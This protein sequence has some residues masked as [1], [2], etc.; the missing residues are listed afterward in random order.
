MWWGQRLGFTLL[1]VMI[2]CAIAVMISAIAVPHFVKMRTDSQIAEAEIHL[3]MIA[4][5]VKQLAW[6]TGRWPGGIPRERLGNPEVW[7]LRISAAG[8]L[9]ADAWRFPN[10]EG[11]Y[12]DEIPKDPW[13]SDYFFDPDYTVNG[14]A[15]PVVGSFGPNRRGR[16]VYDKDNVYVLLD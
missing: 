1:E 4:A 7:D 6:D 2:A 5:A 14:R 3:S 9:K 16:N 15:R 10:W 12:L 8:L 13:G 11:A